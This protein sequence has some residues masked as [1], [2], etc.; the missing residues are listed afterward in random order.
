[1]RAL[2]SAFKHIGVQ[3]GLLFSLM[4]LTQWGFAHS[5]HD[6]NHWLSG[7]IHLLSVLAVVAILY[8]AARLVEKRASR[9]RIK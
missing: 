8:T 4:L 7:A 2:A 9:K 1:M 5:G 3:T 6:H